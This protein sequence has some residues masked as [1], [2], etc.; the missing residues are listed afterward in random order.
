VRLAKG[1]AGIKERGTVPTLAEFAPRFERAIET[2]C[3]DKPA[4][5]S[6]YKEKLR[7]LLDD[8]PLSSARLDQIEEGVIDGYKRGDRGRHRATVGR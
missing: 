7:R 8:S 2:V 3:A 4:T 6:F 1:E 5:V